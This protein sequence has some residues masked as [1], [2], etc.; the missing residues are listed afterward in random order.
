MPVGRPRAKLYIS[1]AALLYQICAFQDTPSL[2]ITD[3]HALAHTFQAIAKLF[4][5]IHLD[6]EVDRQIRVLMRGIYGAPH[7]EI[8]IRRL[9]KQKP[10]KE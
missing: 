10:Q 5:Q 2:K 3:L 9:F 1:N 4:H 8:D 6:V 7:K